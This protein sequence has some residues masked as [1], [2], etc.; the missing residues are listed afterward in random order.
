VGLA[1]DIPIY[2][3]SVVA[4]GWGVRQY[5]FLHIIMIKEYLAPVTLLAGLFTPVTPRVQIKLFLCY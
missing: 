1:V 3:L 4:G 5:S 2:E